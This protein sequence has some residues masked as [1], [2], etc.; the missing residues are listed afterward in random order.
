ML[1]FVS[2][3]TGGGKSKF[4][5]HRIIEYLRFDDRPILYYMA[6]RLDPWVNPKGTAYPGLVYECEKRFGLDPDEVR[7]RLVSLDVDQV[8][9]FWAWRPKIQRLPSG[10]VDR[11]APVVLEQLPPVPLGPDGKEA[12]DAVFSYDG[13]VYGGAVF[14][15][16]EAHEFFRKMDFAKI[17]NEALSWASQNRRAGDDAWL[18]SQRAD[19]VAKP[20]RDQSVECYWMINH[21]HRVVSIFREPARIKYYLFLTTPPSPGEQPDRTGNLSFRNDY[22]NGCYDTAAGASVS[23]GGADIGYRPRGLSWRWLILAA[24]LAVVG[25]AFAWQGLLAM[26]RGTSKATAR[27][28][29]PVEV[30]QLGHALPSKVVATNFAPTR[31]QEM[32]RSNATFLGPTRSQETV[33]PAPKVTGVVRWG[34]FATVYLSDGSSVRSRSGSVVNLGGSVLL[35]GE[36]LKWAK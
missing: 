7:R 12:A 35:N 25:V 22:L 23:G 15:I 20:F 5:C 21:G 6:L 18:L 17:K 3:M 28:L 30:T 26:F 13:N 1:R 29:S 36:E 14:I 9:R 33:S 24:A 32:V 34:Q 8:R 4:M 16:D 27:M 10:V 31:S 2:G 11:R 19:L